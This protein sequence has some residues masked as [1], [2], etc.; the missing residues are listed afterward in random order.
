VLRIL[1]WIGIDLYAGSENFTTKPGSG[2][3]LDNENLVSTVHILIKRKK[4]S[5]NKFIT[6]FKE[7]FFL[8]AA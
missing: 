3:D 6:V 2:T 4:Y 5:L 7:F 8:S 1:V